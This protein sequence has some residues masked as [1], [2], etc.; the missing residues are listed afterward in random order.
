MAENKIL[1]NL[2]G[3]LIK[4]KEL[5]FN[6]EIEKKNNKIQDICPKKEININYEGIKKIKKVNKLIIEHN[7]EY[8]I[9]KEEKDDDSESGE[10]NKKIGKLNMVKDVILSNYLNTINI[11][12][13]KNFDNDYN[14][15][16]FINNINNECE[17][18]PSFLLCLQK[19]KD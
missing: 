5:L 16:D 14:N 11:G 4:E 2:K 9:L 19:E 10:Q 17:P 8:Q 18:I 13:N 3:E 7:N 1:I 12:Y 6:K 15:E